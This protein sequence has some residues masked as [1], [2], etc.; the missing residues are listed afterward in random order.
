[1][2]EERH[3]LAKI[4]PTRNSDHPVI[5][6]WH[7]RPISSR[8]G[9]RRFRR[10]LLVA[11]YASWIVVAVVVKL[12]SFAYPRSN[13]LTWV[14]L[15]ANLAIQAI[16]VGRRTI[17][18]TPTLADAELDERLVQIRNAA[19]RTAFR[20]FAG[21]ALIGWLVSIAAMQWQPN[22]QGFLNAI[23]IFFAVT[24]LASTL[25]TAI[26]AWREPDPPEPEPPA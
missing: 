5:V 11:T 18:S 19:F 1:M 9:S 13:W 24:L 10:R 16:W 8:V 14:L 7:R 23:L 3:W 21:V 26:V 12:L 2:T 25:P 15:S 20:V 4:K 17:I 6:A 22:D